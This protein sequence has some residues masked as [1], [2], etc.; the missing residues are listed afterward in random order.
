MLMLITHV[1]TIFGSQVCMCT[2][3]VCKYEHQFLMIA[4]FSRPQPSIDCTF[5]DMGIQSMHYLDNLDI[6][7]GNCNPLVCLKCM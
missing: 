2:T 3:K 7:I 5:N 4:C 6:F 1:G